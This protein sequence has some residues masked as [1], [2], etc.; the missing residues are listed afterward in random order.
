MRRSII[1]VTLSLVM[2]AGSGAIAGDQIYKCIDPNGATVL[3]DKACEAIESTPA[4]AGAATAAPTPADVPGTVATLPTIA[5]E[6]PAVTK[7]YYKLP[8]A[9]IDRSNRAR[10]QLVSA[11]PKI[12]IATLKAA[13]LSLELSDRTAS[14]R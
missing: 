4:D 12:D 2:L 10:A 6:R 7:E 8:Q 13:K 5:L 11:A 14:L 3:S 9:E 1:P